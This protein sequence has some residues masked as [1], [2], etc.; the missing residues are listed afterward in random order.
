M[1]NVPNFLTLVRI[2]T[3]P[4]FLTAKRKKK[5]MTSTDTAWYTPVKKENRNDRRQQKTDRDKMVVTAV[6]N[7]ADTFH[8]IRKE[9]G[10]GWETR[11]ISNALRRCSKLHTVTKVKRRY[12]PS[13]WR[14]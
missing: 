2:L 10:D 1:L 5:R 6:N 9:L 4:A 12:Y 13:G 3:I 11:D 7:G 14:G 8:K